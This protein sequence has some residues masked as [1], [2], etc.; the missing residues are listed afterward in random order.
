MNANIK[1][2]LDEIIAEETAKVDEELEKALDPWANEELNRFVKA[3][4]DKNAK[5]EAHFATQ[6]K[7]VKEAKEIYMFSKQIY[8]RPEYGPH[9]LTKDIVTKL[10][11]G[12]PLTPLTNNEDDWVECKGSE[13]E[14]Q[15]RRASFLLREKQP[16]GSYR[17]SDESR[18]VGLENGKTFY[19]GFLVDI[20]NEL[21]PVKFPYTVPDRPYYANTMSFN[22]G[23]YKTFKEK[24][25][26]MKASGRH[27]HIVYDTFGI[28]SITRPNGT[29]VPVGKYYRYD[30]GTREEIT[31]QEFKE[32]KAMFDEKVE[33]QLAK[34]AKYAEEH[35]DED[36]VIDVD[37]LKECG[38]E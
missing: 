35:K 25:P 28:F 34:M 32:R 37:V 11:R 22:V 19:M 13:T 18:I 2:N 23:T 8:E 5:N 17:Y 10:W 29:I 3:L 30:N 15:H 1:K 4:S 21:E 9:H 6:L 26:I 33:K 20:L 36:I 16:D 31:Y 24:K 7:H 27:S 38:N 14:D 12:V